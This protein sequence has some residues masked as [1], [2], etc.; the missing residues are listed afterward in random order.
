MNIENGCSVHIFQITNVIIMF[1]IFQYLCVIN[2][3]KGE[4]RSITIRN[5]RSPFDGSTCRGH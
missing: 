3:Q 4:K 2:E 1:I 5:L